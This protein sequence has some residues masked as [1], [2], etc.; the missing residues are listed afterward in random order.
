LSSVMLQLNLQLNP[1][2][3]SRR[4]TRLPE[5]LALWL[6][7][8]QKAPEECDCRFFES[9]FSP[10][11]LTGSF[12]ILMFSFLCVLLGPRCLDYDLGSPRQSPVMLYVEF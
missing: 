7:T 10:D 4:P 12:R 8:L 3:R 5:P 6:E 11:P 2:P 1:L 9:E